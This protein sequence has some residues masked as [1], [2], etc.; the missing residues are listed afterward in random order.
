MPFRALN[1]EQSCPDNSNNNNNFN[2]PLDIL[3]VSEIVS[4]AVLLRVEEDDNGRD[5][6]DHLAGRQQVQVG[7][8]V[9]ASIAVHPFQLRLLVRRRRHLGQGVRLDQRRRSEQLKTNPM[10]RFT[11]VFYK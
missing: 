1:L 4:L 6:V 9:F 8:R 3:R 5:E 2:L 11:F 7:A 10:K